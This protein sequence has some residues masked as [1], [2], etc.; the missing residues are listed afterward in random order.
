MAK[1]KPATKRAPR[2][3]EVDQYFEG[4]EP[5]KI[6]EIDRAVI[7]L[8]EAKQTLSAAK[9]EVV[10]AEEKLHSLMNTHHDALEKAANGRPRYLAKELQ[11]IVV[12]TQASESVK[13]KKMP[14][15][16]E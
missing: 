4:M 13:V 5:P 6:A 7:K 12:L 15:V 1:K 8:E 16:K 14:K 3:V 11:L 9:D 2:R 10:A